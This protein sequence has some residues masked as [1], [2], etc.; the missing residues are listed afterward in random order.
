MTK[1][2][3]YFVRSKY[4]I[5]LLLIFSVFL[6]LL[7]KD[8]FSQR[9]LI[10]NFEPYPDTFY[11]INPAL[12]LIKGMGFNINREGKV[13]YAN[14]PPLYAFSLIPVFLLRAD[15]RMAYY[16][17]VLL[18]ITS[19]FFFWAIL[20]KISPNRVITY[21]LIIIYS[22]NYF[23]YWVP[24]LIMAEN[25]ILTLYLAAIFFLISEV[26]IRNSL[27]IAFLAMGI[28]A[29]KFASIPVLI[30]IILLFFIKVLFGRF[31]L[32]QK[33]RYG[34]IFLVTILICFIVLEI[35]LEINNHVSLISRVLYN[36]SLIQTS[37]TEVSGVVEKPSSA[38]WF[39]VQYIKQNLP[40]YINSLL[41]NPNRFLWDNTPLV[42]KLIALGGITGILGGFLNKKF[43][44]IS[45]VLLLFMVST[46]IFQSMFY[47]FDAR[48]IYIA[49]PSLIMGFGFLLIIFSQG[50]TLKRSLIVNTF[51]LILLTVYLVSSSSRIKDQISLNLRH[52]ETPWHYIA[53]LE[54]NKYFIADKIKSSKKP[55]LISAQ[56]PF[57][58]DYFTNGNY[59]LLPLSSEQEFRGQETREIVWGPNDYSDLPRLYTKYLK[60][61]F[62]V[63]VSRA[64][65]GNEGYTNRDF[66]TI[67][68]KFE[69]KLVQPGCYDQCNIYSVKLKEKNGN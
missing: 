11:Y 62:D 36:L 3:S 19:F 26:T 1:L 2:I 13:Y 42:P 59:T 18:A 45:L 33:I 29:T 30:S 46:I 38:A 57:L 22:T 4:I 56:P 43:R 65:L 63:Y 20:K 21:F 10:P 27:I 39:G 50:I 40:L 25:L 6:L 49:I 28:Y 51:I 14:V 31:E 55:I 12:N 9:T 69:T 53:V 34:L 8:P 5:G 60:E 58:V 16:S 66:N 52:A 7:F 41:G 54:A 64:G 32:N 15:P 47:S 44:F 35:F 48:Y 23:I 67:V 68:E 37:L 17:N 24:S 61:G